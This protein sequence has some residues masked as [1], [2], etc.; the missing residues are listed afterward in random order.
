MGV[1]CQ[2]AKGVSAGDFVAVSVLLV[3]LLHASCQFKSMGTQDQ[4]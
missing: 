3:L 1:D 4:P 2:V